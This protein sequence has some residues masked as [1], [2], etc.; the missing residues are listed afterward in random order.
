MNLLLNLLIIALNYNE[1]KC[2]NAD[3]AIDLNKIK[4]IP[5]YINIIKNKSGYDFRNNAIDE[6]NLDVLKS[7]KKHEILMTLQSPDISIFEKMNIIEEIDVSDSY[8]YNIS[9]GGLFDD[10]NQPI[11]DI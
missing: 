10:W 2:N 8:L 7:I 3:M 1:K 11:F 6:I 4:K 9:K 5:D